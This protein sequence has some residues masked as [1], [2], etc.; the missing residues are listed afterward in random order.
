M[1]EHSLQW[2]R[3]GILLGQQGGEELSAPG[4]QHLLVTPPRFPPAANTT[5]LQSRRILKDRGSFRLTV[6]LQGQEGHLVTAV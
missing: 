1:S 4:R 5:V 3:S 2:S 6:P